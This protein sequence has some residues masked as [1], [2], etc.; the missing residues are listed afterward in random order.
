[1]ENTILKKILED[2]TDSNDIPGDLDLFE[3]G[4]IDSLGMIRLLVEIEEQL[5]V[6]IAITEIER[7]Q[8]CTLNLISDY[9]KGK[10]E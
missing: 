7:E 9:I 2:I 8:F 10:L 4:L 3:N 1:M 5:G 6:Y